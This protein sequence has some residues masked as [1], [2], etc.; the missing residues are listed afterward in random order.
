VGADQLSILNAE[1][2]RVAEP[3]EVDIFFGENSTQT[4]SGEVLE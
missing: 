1:M 2:K 4:Q 3:G